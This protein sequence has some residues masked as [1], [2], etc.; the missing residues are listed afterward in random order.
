M[1]RGYYA[2]VSRLNG[3]ALDIEGASLNPGAFVIPWDKHLA[4]NQLWYDDAING[5]IRSKLNSFCL[6]IEGLFIGCFF[7]PFIFHFIYSF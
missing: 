1:Q 4:D 5:T 6:D 3:L 2:I 7:P